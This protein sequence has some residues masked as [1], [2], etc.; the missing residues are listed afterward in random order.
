MLWEKTTT[1][2]T[3]SVSKNHKIGE[4]TAEALQ[5]AHVQ[6]HLFCKSHTVEGFDRSNLSVLAKKK[7]LGFREKLQTINPA[8]KSFLRGK[9]TVVAA[10]ITSILSLV[11]HDKSAHST[12]QADLFDYIL[13][14]EGQV[15]H[16]A[17]YYERRFTK[18][19]Y[20]AAFILQ[21]LPYLYM[22]LNE[23]HLS[24]QHTEIVQMF[25]DPEFLIT[26]LQVPADFT[27]CVTLPFLYFV[28][29]NSQE[30]LLEMFPQLFNDLKSGTLDTL[31][32]FQVKYPHV[33]V[34]QPI[35][36]V[37]QQLLKK[38]CE[39]AAAVLDRQAGREYGFGVGGV[40][41]TPRVTQLHLL[42]PDERAGLPTNNIDAERHLAVFGKRAP[43]PK[44]KN[45]KFTAKGI[46]MLRYSNQ[47]LSRKNKVKDFLLLSGFSTTWRKIGLKNKNNSMKL[48]S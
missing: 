14:R 2:I 42:P 37:A 43:V 25:L 29:V 23:S 47:G 4:G 7:E 3:D 22:L 48:R 26:E 15:K 36:D 30:K 21:L 35:T 33:Q 38:M 5:S 34:T 19:G 39:D 20:S 13:Q 8:V 44:F 40:D 18:L 41:E 1:I 12:N 6:Y 16:I 24:N 32:E 28:E 46:E 27:H 9:T 10:A 17:M 11:S 45:K 31:K